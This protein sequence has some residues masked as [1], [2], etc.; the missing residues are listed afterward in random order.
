MIALEEGPVA[1]ERWNQA[2]FLSHLP[3]KTI[4]AKFSAF[5]S[6]HTFN[7]QE[8]NIS[9]RSWMN[10]LSGSA[11][12][13]NPWSAA[14]FQRLAHSFLLRESSHSTENETTP[15]PTLARRIADGHAFEHMLHDTI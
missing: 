8:A 9:R 3:K 5:N 12:L 13:S 7:P 11:D 2:H 15:E 14:Y 10:S 6:T 4:L 1:P